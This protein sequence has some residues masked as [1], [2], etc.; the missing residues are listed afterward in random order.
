MGVFYSFKMFKMS[1]MDKVVLFLN[2]LHP[3]IPLRA[4]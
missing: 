4:G 2:Q 3:Y 1:T